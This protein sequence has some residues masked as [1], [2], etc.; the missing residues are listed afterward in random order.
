MKC[1]VMGTPVGF[2]KIVTHVAWYDKMWK[3][4]KKWG[5]TRL[6]AWIFNTR[7]RPS[8]LNSIVPMFSFSK[9]GKL[10]YLGSMSKHHK[11]NNFFFVSRATSS[12][13]DLDS[14]IT[15]NTEVTT[16]HLT[17]E[18]KLRL[19]TPRCSLSHSSGE[20]CPITDPFWAFYWPGGQ[21]LTRSDFLYWSA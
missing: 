13:E 21:A 1:D 20:D 18:I 11:L 16:N 10:R 14:F 17:P 5:V 19:I 7:T 12:V 15:K 6:D 4:T 2:S 9:I 3:K 8:C